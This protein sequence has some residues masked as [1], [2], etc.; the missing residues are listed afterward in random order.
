[1]IISTMDKV[2]AV[3]FSELEKRGWLHAGSKNP[4]MVK[5][6]CLF[7]YHNG[8]NDDTPVTSFKYDNGVTNMANSRPVLLN[9][10]NCSWH[11]ERSGWLLAKG[12]LSP[13]I[14]D[15]YE[16][17]DWEQY[18]ITTE[19]LYKC[20]DE[21]DTL[22][23]KSP[24]SLKAY[25]Q[26]L[27]EK[28]VDKVV[29]TAVL[30]NKI[31]E[32]GS[33]FKIIVVGLALPLDPD[34]VYYLDNIITGA[35]EVKTLTPSLNGFKKNGDIEI[36]A[37][38]FLT[39]VKEKYIQACDIEQE[40]VESTETVWAPL[41]A[42]NEDV[43]F[44]KEFE[45]LNIPSDKKHIIASAFHKNYNVTPM[46]NPALSRDT[47]EVLYKYG[48]DVDLSMFNNVALD[49]D[50]AFELLSLAKQGY[51]I[52]SLIDKGYSAEYLKA[53]FEDSYSELAVKDKQL[54]EQG[55][56]D[57]QIKTL[58]HIAFD[59][60]DT[61]TLENVKYSALMMHML[62][63]T[64]KFPELETIQK[65]FR[66]KAF[67]REELYVPADFLSGEEL[68]ALRKIMK[69]D[70]AL[71]IG[72]MLWQEFIEK[73]LQELRYV[74]YTKKHGFILKT[75]GY[76]VGFEG[77]SYFVTSVLGEP[78]WRAICVNGRFVVNRENEKLIFS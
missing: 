3:L 59:G 63:Y 60:I 41:I 4:V 20:I 51:C 61:S 34:K 26:H 22:A 42:D 25:K 24:V 11:V 38:V 54:R 44:P 8:D 23:N 6:N 37:D 28:K 73:T 36:A 33:Y 53:I 19:A 50:A 32:L 74:T 16:A 78:R 70:Y 30:S 10:A 31:I 14:A 29:K 75:N 12:Q 68:A 77:N 49:R 69:T 65:L 45:E 47:L 67:M 15:L 27:Q 17:D 39:L 13:S 18:P 2:Q 7:V 57:E 21:V 64:S 71:T 9:P 66:E 56:N 76:G 55:F 72:D 1:M 35:M 40:I 46:L 48:D 58:I 43:D 52:D 5:N 62:W